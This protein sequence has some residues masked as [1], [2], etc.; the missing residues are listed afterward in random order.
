MEK[1]EREE[2]DFHF[3]KKNFEIH[4]FDMW[5]MCQVKVNI[6]F[7]QLLGEVS[8]ISKIVEMLSDI[9]RNLKG[10]FWYYPFF[11]NQT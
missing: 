11:Q 5:I 6:V 7:L 3:F 2:S 10:G 8:D 1:R 9:K 4:L